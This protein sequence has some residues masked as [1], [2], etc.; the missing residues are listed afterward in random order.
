MKFSL[1]RKM[2]VAEGEK[3]IVKGRFE[4]QDNIVY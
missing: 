1:Y 3:E 4:K 2:S